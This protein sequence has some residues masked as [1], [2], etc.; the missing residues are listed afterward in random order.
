MACVVCILPP[1]LPLFFNA[2][3]EEPENITPLASYIIAI[4][5]LKTLSK[6]RRRSIPAQL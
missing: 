3:N 5:I 1:V 2:I 4:A 6:I